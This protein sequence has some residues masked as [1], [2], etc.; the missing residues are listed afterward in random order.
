RTPWPLLPLAATACLLVVLPLVALV[1]RVPWS[2]LGAILARPLV[3][4]ALR[5]SLVSATLA[6]GASLVLGVPLAWV[7]A[8]WRFP[9]ASLA[10]AVVLLPMV[11]PPVVG[12]AALLF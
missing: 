6:T 5:L 7:L 3:A 11:L 2:D 8:R 9:G 1:V 12:G 4:D 10:R